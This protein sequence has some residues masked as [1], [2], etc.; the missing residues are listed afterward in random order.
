VTLSLDGPNDLR[1]MRAGGIISVLD[2]V[3]SK[4]GGLGSPELHK[5]NK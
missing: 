3:N 4:L 5:Q 2:T 1:L